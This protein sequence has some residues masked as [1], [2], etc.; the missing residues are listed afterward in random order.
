MT[1]SVQHRRRALLFALAANAGFLVVELVGGFL[2]GS[3]AL[4][5]DATHMTADV[6]ALGIALGALALAQRPPTARHTYGFARAEVLAALFNGVLLIAGA[7]VVLVEAFRRIDN[8]QHIDGTGVLVVGILGLA[9]NAGSAFALLGDA[10]GDLNVRGAF[11]HLVADALGSVAVIVAALGALVFGTDRLD[12]IASVAI[13]VL[14]LLAAWRVLRDAT[15][16]LLEG[17][18]TG[19]DLTAVR[20]ALAGSA[21]VEAVH[22]LH[23]WSIGSAHVALSAHVVLG[24]PLSLHD[25]QVRAGAMKTMLAEQF[26]IEHATIE[27]ECHACVDDDEHLHR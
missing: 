18:P 22:D 5:A 8:P 12:S 4:L 13:A 10:R 16:V 9:V 3:L 21:G 11:W 17:V 6:L 14:V 20:A 1:R 26:H 15:R 19:L 25:A 7:G 23:V 24:G 27:V 2:F